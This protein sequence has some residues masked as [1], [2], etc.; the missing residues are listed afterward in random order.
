MKVA[1]KVF[2][3]KQD[4]QKLSNVSKSFLLDIYFHMF[5]DYFHTNSVINPIINYLFN[6]PVGDFYKK[7]RMD[8]HTLKPI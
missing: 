2:I 6:E 3:M 5:M 1:E 7:K 8:T 4:I